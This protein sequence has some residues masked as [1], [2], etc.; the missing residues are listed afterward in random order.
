M[1]VAIAAPATPSAG[2]RGCADEQPVE[3][4]VHPVGGEVDLHGNM[5]I[6]AAAHGR[7]DGEGNGGKKLPEQDDDEI[8]LRHIDGIRLR[9]EK[10]RVVD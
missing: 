4:D 8:I 5:R 7:G 2:N 10:S 3:D 9:A 6:A 1:T